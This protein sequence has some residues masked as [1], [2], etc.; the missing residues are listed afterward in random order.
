MASIAERPL[1]DSVLRGFQASSLVAAGALLVVGS[2]YGSQTSYQGWQAVNGRMAWIA[3]ELVSPA[4]LLYAF[5]GN[6][7]YDLGVLPAAV[8][9]SEPSQDDQLFDGPCWSARNMLVLAWLLHYA[10]RAVVYPL[11]QTSRKPMHLG[12]VLAAVVF[13]TINGYLNGRWLATYAPAEHGQMFTSYVAARCM[14]R[15]LGLVLFAAGMCGN[16]YHDSILTSLRCSQAA[17]RYSIPHGGLFGLVSCPHY[18]CEL[19]EWLGYALLSD[20]P[21]AWTF[22]LNAACNLVPRA[23]FI[24]RWYQSAFPGEYPSSRRAILPFLL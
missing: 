12:I 13:N 23:R 20:S 3:M 19:V 18:L 5:L 1:F 21:A 8:P 14:R 16:I 15:V 11:R 2:P 17:Q 24:H 9:A 7:A 10:Y 6:P 22:L 4:M